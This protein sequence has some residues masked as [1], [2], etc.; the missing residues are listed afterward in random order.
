MSGDLAVQYMFFF[1]VILVV[2]VI[3]LETY[4]ILR[5]VFEKLIRWRRYGK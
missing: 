3:F 1:A 2:I 5:M 4:D